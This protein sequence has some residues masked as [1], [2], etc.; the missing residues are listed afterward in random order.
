ME[1][2]WIRKANEDKEVEVEGEGDDHRIFEVK[3]VVHF[4]FLPEGQTVNQTIYKEIFLC[5]MKSV[6]DKKR[7]L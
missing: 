3:G 1:K 4:E 6:R 7:D 5:L 2:P